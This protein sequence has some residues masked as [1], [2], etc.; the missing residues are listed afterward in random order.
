MILLEHH[1]VIVHNDDSIVLRWR[2]D[3]H[4]YVIAP[5]TSTTIPFPLACKELG[6]P[7]SGGQEQVVKLEGGQLL[8]IPSRE[9]ERK[10]LDV[11]YGCSARI[12]EAKMERG[13]VL[14]VS[15]PEIAPKVRVTTTDGEPISTVIDDWEGDRQLILPSDLDSPDALRAQIA[16]QQRQLEELK[17][18]F[19]ARIANPDTTDTIPEDTPGQAVSVPVSEPPVDNPVTLEV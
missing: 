1:S 8:R 9:W 10:R 11:L 2:W 3:G 14:S 17:R 13:E 6:D 4:E 5:G 18:L 15:V 19:E 12:V 16:Q 7:R